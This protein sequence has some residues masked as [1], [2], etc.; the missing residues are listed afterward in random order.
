MKIRI[1]IILVVL[2]IFCG[3]YAN[4]QKKNKPNFTGTWILDESTS[5]NP[6]QS[7]K[8]SP[9]SV[10]PKRKVVRFIIIEHLDPAFNVTERQ[11]VETFND[12][13]DLTEKIETTLSK[14]VY[15]TDKRG[16]SNLFQSNQVHS[17]ITK[18][19]GKDVFVVVT[20]DEKKDNSSIFN[21]ALSKD[22]KEL[23]IL[24]L[25][26]QI[27]Y[28]LT[29]NGNYSLPIPIGGKNVYKKVG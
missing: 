16:E 14:L 3:S 26:Q 29:S 8:K 2:T 1:F 5:K 13:G 19:N 27:T 25:G 6:F 24:N 11:Q 4:A 12:A 7:L 28:D 21:F 15:Y 22:G 23:T 20:L 18:W 17:S 10:D 9:Q